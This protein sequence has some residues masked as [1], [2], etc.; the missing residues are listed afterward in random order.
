M[1]HFQERLRKA[2]LRRTPEERNYWVVPDP[3]ID[4]SLLMLG[5]Q[6]EIFN[7]EGFARAFPQTSVYLE[8]LRKNANVRVMRDR[9]PFSL[10]V[11][12]LRVKSGEAEEQVDEEQELD[13]DGDPANPPLSSQT[14]WTKIK[15]WRPW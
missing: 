15:T 7:M 10:A 6:R 5:R 8:N 4:A 13:R 3:T 11:Q 12:A 14:Y 9:C 2:E 1:H